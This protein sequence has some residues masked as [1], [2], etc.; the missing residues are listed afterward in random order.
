MF[1]KILV[2]TDGSDSARTAVK[3]AAEIA[4]MAKSLSVLIIHIC[5]A[6]VAD[7]D[8][9]EENRQIA[10]RIL[11]DAAAEFGDM[12]N[13]VDVSVEVDY[14]PESIGSA[15]VDIAKRENATLIV[16]GSRGL[17]EFKGMLLGSVSNKV[18]QH[19][20]CPVLI[21]RHEC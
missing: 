1:S 2:A 6:C 4:K 14:P 8:P 21:V 12:Q 13:I 16:V 10:D 5:P 19:S 9:H 17:S 11:A 20:H 7:V 3:H 15:I 18:A